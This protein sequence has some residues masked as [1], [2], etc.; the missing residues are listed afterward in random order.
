M[1][2]AILKDG[3]RKFKGKNA[4]YSNIMAAT[5]LG[6]AM[7]RSL[8]P[9]GLD[10]MLVDA[11]GNSTVTND[12]ATLLKRMEIQHPIGKMLVEIAKTQDEMVGDGTTTVVILAGELLREA[13]KLLDKK[14]HPSIIMN[15]YE[16]ACKKA[17]EIMKD[18]ALK[19]DI[20]DE[21]ML[22]KVAEVALS[23]KMLVEHK[24]IL[25]ELI[26]SAALKVTKKTPKG[27]DIDLD[28]MS[29]QRKPG[30]SLDE[31]TLVNGVII[32]KE[33]AHMAM[34]RRVENA[35]IALIVLP[36]EIKKTTFDS[37]INIQNPNQLKMFTAE[38]EN[39]LRRMVGKL[40]DL[41]ANILF[42]QRE[43][44]EK[45]Q[46]ILANENILAVKR[47]KVADMERIAKATGGKIITTI[48]DLE[49]K[50]L[51]SAKLV[52]ERKFGKD[53]LVL[54]EGCKNPKAVTIFIRGGTDKVIDEARR[55]IL[56]GLHVL[57]DVINEPLVLGGGGASEMQVSRKLVSFAEKTKGKEQLAIKSFAIALE[58]IPE[59]LVEN[60]GHRSID[61]LT[62][63]RSDHKRGNIWSGVSTLDGKVIDTYENTVLEPLIVKTQAISSANEAAQIILKIDDVIAS[64]K[65]EIEDTQAKDQEE[66]TREEKKEII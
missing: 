22:R 2:V 41:G 34:P 14:V 21:A 16:I 54:I 24:D 18:V 63:L 62:K 58:S 5:I 45:A 38:E 11:I 36:F 43:M 23:T 4:L 1:P 46:K 35:K 51:G 3:D 19:I 27:Y 53:K 44:S 20:K 26:V 42:C 64:S 65:S 59:T 31:T 60:A 52:R 49:I 28:D 57:K 50:D 9:N 55:S 7:K 30:G 13:R 56:D 29:I 47:V 40:Q 37:K 25:A 17:Q 15:G 48:D 32:D 12:G 33:I 66:S 8:G 39:M 61:I 10:K 6:E